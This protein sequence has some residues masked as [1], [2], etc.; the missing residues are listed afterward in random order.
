MKASTSAGE[1]LYCGAWR[2]TMSTM[3]RGASGGMISA[4]GAAVRG[5]GGVICGGVR[6]I[7]H[8]GT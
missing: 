6:S 5:G 8:S 4:G 7:M 1:S 3:W 2:L